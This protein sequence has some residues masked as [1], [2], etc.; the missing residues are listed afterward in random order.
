M[1]CLYILNSIQGYTSLLSC[2]D[3]L[4]LGKSLLEGK[5][6]EFVM[7]VLIWLQATI[8]RCLSEHSSKS[9]IVR[10]KDIKAVK[11]QLSQL[12]REVSHRI[13]VQVHTGNRT[14]VMD[15]YLL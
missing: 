8:K 9:E 5:S 14:K 6:E 10:D 2:I 13:L 3:F 11:H 1:H 7:V 15:I 4:T 12:W